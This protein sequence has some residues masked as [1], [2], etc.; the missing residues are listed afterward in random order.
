MRTITAVLALVM[1]T[2]GA[3]LDGLS[4]SGAAQREVLQR[5]PERPDGSRRYLFYLHGRLVEDH[6]PDAVSPDYGPYEYSAIIRQLSAEGFT[7]ISGIR[8]PKTDPQIYSEGVADQIGH[9][10]A[11]GVAPSH[12]TVVGASKGSVIAMLVSSRLTSAVR[13]VLLANC[14]DY[15]LKAFSLSLHGDVLSIYED[16]DDLGRTCVPLFDQSPD[17]GRRQEVRLTTGL[18]HGFI[19]RPLAD[20]L[21]PAVAWAR[22]GA[23]P[24]EPHAQRR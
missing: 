10:I 16:S 1:W 14:N 7:V 19:F 11:A 9:L 13:Y 8:P 12:I 17:L 20:W 2:T 22:T 15:V 23:L 24:I 3:V 5:A 6:G 4:S 18:R 21:R